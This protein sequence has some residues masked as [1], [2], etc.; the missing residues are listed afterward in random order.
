MPLRVLN[1][2]STGWDGEAIEHWL[3]D[4]PKDATWLVASVNRRGTT[5]LTDFVERTSPDTQTRLLGFADLPVRIA[6]AEPERVGIDRLAGAAAANRL[7]DPAR[8]AIVIQVGTAIT[9]NLIAADGTFRG[10]AILPGI[11]M[12]ARALAQNTDLLPSVAIEDLVD[13]QPAI[14]TTTIEAIRSGLYWGAVGAM[15][16][17]IG[18]F[19][20]G[21][22]QPAE[23]FLTGGAA[24]SVAATLDEGARYVEHLV[25]AGIALAQSGD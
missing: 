16:E 24:P 19:S 1:L 4:V 17:L 3:Q 23:V 7:R 12:S 11:A 6:L 10:G 14:G 21:L 9:A 8:P 13:P 20:V 5:E 25:L 22:D 18:R 2:P 15:R